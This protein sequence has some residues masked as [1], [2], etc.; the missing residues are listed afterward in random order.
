MIARNLHGIDHKLH[1]WVRPIESKK[2]AAS[3]AG[4]SIV[5]VAE[6]SID[7]TKSSAD[8]A[9]SNADAGEEDDIV[10]SPSGVVYD[11]IDFSDP[12]PAC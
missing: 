12:K 9:E 1:K 3:D 8:G 10:R 2:D 4:E 11:L 7:G 5:D 6:S